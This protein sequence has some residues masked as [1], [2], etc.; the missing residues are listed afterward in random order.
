MSE[1]DKKDEFLSPILP[2]EEAIRS[3][4]SP[5]TAKY[6]EMRMNQE[7]FSIERERIR[8]VQAMNDEIAHMKQRLLYSVCG[9]MQELAYSDGENLALYKQMCPDL[10]TRFTQKGTRKRMRKKPKMQK[11]SMSLGPLEQPLPRTEALID[12]S[13]PDPLP[14]RPSTTNTTEAIMCTKKGQKWYV[15]KN[16]IQDSVTQVTYCDGSKSLLTD[17]D[18]KTIKIRFE[19]VIEP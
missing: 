17:N 1:C 7:M 18:I 9:K 10:F 6:V 4:F 2:Q 11:I 13:C 19:P 12:I 14:P 16:Q 5:E 3:T 8:L 15:K